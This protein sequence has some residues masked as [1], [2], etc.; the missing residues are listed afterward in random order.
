MRLVKERPPLLQILVVFGGFLVG[1]WASLQASL[2]LVPDSDLVQTVS[3]FAFTLVFVGGTLFW[4][5]FGI[6]SVVV[7]AVWRLVRGRLPGSPAPDAGDRIVPPGY[8]IYLILGCG[9]GLAVGLLAGVA[10]DLTIETAM[11]TWTM[12]GAAYGWLLW[13]AAHHGYLPFPEPE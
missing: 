4:A 7:A 3:V 12:M 13:L 6:A 1:P 5:G 2:Y 10:T 11:A 8:R 9:A